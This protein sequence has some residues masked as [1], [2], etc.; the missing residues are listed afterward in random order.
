MGSL[1]LLLVCRLDEAG[2]AISVVGV[3]FASREERR[4][5][6]FE[7]PMVFDEP[8]GI[9]GPAAV[10]SGG[11]RLGLVD[12]AGSVSPVAAPAGSGGAS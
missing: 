6:W 3:L 4:V 7:S 5:S 8:F 1:G 12:V 10:T 9:G 11:A 2:D